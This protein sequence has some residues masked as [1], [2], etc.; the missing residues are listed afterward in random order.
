ML[1]EFRS[2]FFGKDL[3]K[4]NCF[5]LLERPHDGQPSEGVIAPDEECGE[6]ASG[7]S[8]DCEIL[9]AQLFLILADICRYY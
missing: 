3:L 1:V 5:K 2:Q 7:E 8:Q 6:C 4:L 9:A